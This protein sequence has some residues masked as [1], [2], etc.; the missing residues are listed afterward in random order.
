VCGNHATQE[1]GIRVGS[2]EFQ[3]GQAMLVGLPEL[4]LLHGGLGGAVVLGKSL[5]H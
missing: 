3:D 4:P 5:E 2:V 1:P